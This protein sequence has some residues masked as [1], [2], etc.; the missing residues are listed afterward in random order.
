MKDNE[1][2]SSD[3]FTNVIPEDCTVKEFI[4]KL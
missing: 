4:L 2:D 1:Q 3:F